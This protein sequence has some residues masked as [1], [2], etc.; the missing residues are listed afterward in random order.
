MQVSDKE[1]A[2][3]CVDPSSASTAITILDATSGETVAGFDTT[4]VGAA[5]SCYEASS[6][7]FAFLGVNS[8][9]LQMLV[10]QPAS[11]TSRPD[12]QALSGEVRSNL[13]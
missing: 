11:R 7:S 9:Q 10:A 1:I 13:N 4:N 8:N 3:L 12:S 2:I 6:R 5:F